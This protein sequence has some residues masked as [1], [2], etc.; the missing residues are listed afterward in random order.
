LPLATG[1]RWLDLHYVPSRYPN[2]LPSGY[3]H[4]FYDRGTAEQAVSAAER[5]LGAVTGHYR[6]A[7]ETGI[8]EPPEEGGE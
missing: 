6:A 7:G 1:H 2:G 5:I 4:A 3:P 8:L